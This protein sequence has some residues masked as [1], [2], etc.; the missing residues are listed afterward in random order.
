MTRLSPTNKYNLIVLI[1]GSVSAKTTFFSNINAIISVYFDASKKS[2]IVFECFYFDSHQTQ[3]CR[4]PI[5]FF[6]CHLSQL[7]GEWDMFYWFCTIAF[8][9]LP[10]TWRRLGFWTMKDRHYSAAFFWQR[11]RRKS[12]M[13]KRCK[14][15]LCS[16]CLDS[17]CLGAIRKD[18][19]IAQYATRILMAAI[20]SL[21]KSYEIGY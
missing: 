6:Y 12:W 10:S 13:L 9:E 19:I 14:T 3:E 17:S 8:Q 20:V 15:S 5:S 18:E 7:N 1:I 4:Q 21:M 16:S 11:K 2:P